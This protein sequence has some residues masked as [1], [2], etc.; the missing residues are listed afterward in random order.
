M[1]VQLNQIN[2]NK[3]TDEG[4]SDSFYFSRLFTLMPVIIS[5]YLSL[6]SEIVKYI[7]MKTY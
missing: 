7:N 2:K 4:I 3:Q 6:S 5:I 1:G